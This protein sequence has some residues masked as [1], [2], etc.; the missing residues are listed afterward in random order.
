MI[1]DTA[2]F[3][4]ESEMT[5]LS[6]I[7][8]DKDAIHVA[9]STV[10]SSYFFSPRCREIYKTAVNLVEQEKSIDMLSL[11]DELRNTNKLEEVGGVEWVS[12]V[13]GYAPTSQAI[14]HH[15]D[16]IRSLAIQRSFIGKMTRYIE[17][18]HK[19]SD[20]PSALLEDA[21]GSVF[22]LMNKASEKGADKDVFTPKQLAEL[23]FTNAKARFENPDGYRGLQTGIRGLDKYI[24]Q[25]RDLNVVAASTGV[26]KTAL[27]LNIALNLALQKIPVLYINLEM[28]IDQIMCRVLANLSGVAVDE[29]ELGEY[30]DPSRF[31]E[32]ARIASKI[33]NSEL[34]ITHNKSKNI[35][36]IISLINKYHSKYG[37][38]LVIIDYIG[39]IDGDER[40]MKENNRRISLGRYNQLLKKTCVPLD[41]KALVVA[42]M[43]R[44]G[45][46]E[47]DIGNVG[48]CWQLA[49]D[50][51]LF[52]ILYFEMMKNSDTGSDAPEQFKQYYIKGAKNRNGR[53]P[54]I[55]PI[56]YNQNT[57]TITEADGLRTGSSQ[58]VRQE[59]MQALKAASSL[60]NGDNC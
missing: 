43:N 17:Q 18:A 9:M 3:S 56:N 28:D 48:E 27:S 46:K 15:C 52:M 30:K 14:T 53:A 40:S 8:R 4:E 29:I 22:N 16:K 41:I 10:D 59:G 31:A 37:I 26:G 58:I 13:E 24:K 49:Q 2:P 25:L 7:L 32:V 12:V 39:H 54:F 45:D 6:S 19:I 33:E 47:P 50:A 20:D 23:S 34:Y 57:Q 35:N 11:C 51:D 5:I 60:F 21:Y 38:K 55:V 42:Q 44:D 1:T 36:K